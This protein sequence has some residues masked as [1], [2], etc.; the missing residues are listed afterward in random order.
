MQ[1]SKTEKQ[2]KS[3]NLS[4]A[5]IEKVDNY[6]SLNGASFSDIVE[7]GLTLFFEALE[8]GNNSIIETLGIEDPNNSIL[9]PLSLYLK[10]NNITYTQVYALEKSKKIVIKTITEKNKNNSKSKF[11]VL[12]E[13]NPEFYK[14]KLIMMEQKVN[15]LN[16]QLIKTK[17]TVSSNDIP[18]EYK[19]KMEIMEEKLTEA[20]NK[21]DELTK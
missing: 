4:V 14:A 10:M 2:R 12:H 11:V 19:E 16:E 5:I 17:E 6:S 1:H 3:V 15:N 8:K 13:E 18:E 7:Q 9:V 21:V 20:L